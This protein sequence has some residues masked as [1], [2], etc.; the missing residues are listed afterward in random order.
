MGMFGGKAKTPRHQLCSSEAAFPRPIYSAPPDSRLKPD[1]RNG[2][3]F[4]APEAR[5]ESYTYKQTRFTQA[6]LITSIGIAQR[7]ESP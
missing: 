7:L 5:P 1:P 6:V 2:Q 4:L 3:S